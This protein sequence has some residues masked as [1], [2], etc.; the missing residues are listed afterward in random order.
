MIKFSIIV[1][2]LNTKNK[3]ENTLISIIKQSLKSYEIVVVDGKS[4]DGTVDI[5][6]KYKKKLKKIIIKKDKGIYFAMNRGIRI[7]SND[8]LIFMNSGDTFYSIN[9]L[10]KI[11]SNIKRNENIDILVGNAKIIKDNFYYKKKFKKLS[12]KSLVSCFSHQ[13]CTIRRSLQKKNY[14]KTKYKIAADF[15]FFVEVYKKKAKFLYINETISVNEAYGLSDKERFLALR[16]F[17]DINKSNANINCKS[18]KYFL[19][20]VYFLTNF[21]AKSIIPLFL[22]KKLLRLKLKFN[23]LI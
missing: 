3:L 15:N 23:S 11:A 13:S 7:A 10:K 12:S 6:S 17:R 4:N 16:E 8:W 14:F 5:I 19:L 21:V 9:S 22:Q 2:S 18:I 1:V 20:M